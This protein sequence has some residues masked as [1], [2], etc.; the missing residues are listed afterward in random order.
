MSKLPKELIIY[1]KVP[2]SFHGSYRGSTI[3]I[4]S[5]LHSDDAGLFYITVTAPDGTYSYDG[6]SPEEV[7][8]INQAVLEALKGAE[9][10]PTREED[11][12]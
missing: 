4:K 6:W 7:R 12:K 3:E 9:L 8:T 5:N 1:H 2:S 11:R 10:L